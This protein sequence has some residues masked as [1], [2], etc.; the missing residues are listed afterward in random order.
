MSVSQEGINTPD[1]A[2]EQFQSSGTPLSSDQAVVPEQGTAW[3]SPPVFLN[4][5]SVSVGSLGLAC[6]LI[7]KALL[8]PGTCLHQSPDVMNYH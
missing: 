3:F 1:S 8:P 4:H 5:T 2:A 6:P 7:L